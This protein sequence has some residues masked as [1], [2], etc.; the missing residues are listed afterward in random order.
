M[1]P[2]SI[3]KLSAEGS[4]VFVGQ[5]LVVVSSLVLVRLLTEHL[6]EQEY[7]NFTLGLTLAG[8]V[9]QTITGGV[10]AGM[11]R[12]YSVASESDALPEYHQ[13][14][15]KLNLKAS[16][17]I[18]SLIIPAAILFGIDGIQQHAL[19]IIFVISYAAL[20]S[21]FTISNSYYVASRKRRFSAINLVIDAWLRVSL[22]VAAVWAFPKTAESVFLGYLVASAIVCLLHVILNNSIKR[23]YRDSGENYFRIYREIQNYSMPFAIWGVFAWLQQS[24]DKWSLSYFHSVEST[25]SYAVLY[26]LGYSPMLMFCG[27]ITSFLAPIIFQKAGSGSDQER[28]KSTQDLIYKLTILGFGTVIAG[29]FFTVAFGDILIKIFVSD[30]FSVEKNYLHWL[31]LA[32]GLFSIGQLITLRLVSELNSKKLIPL[33]IGSSLLGVIYTVGLAKWYG[34]GGVVLSANLF[35]LTYLVWALMLIRKLNRNS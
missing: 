21:V 16:L 7:G 6:S 29:F 2:R 11:R 4:W 27:L 23:N 8:L 34:V 30:T 14:K 18:S 28:M 5:L 25:G 31:V 1:N 33:K 15:D 10:A 13:A 17:M 12:F 3:K 19:L 9:N 20:N 35:G 32:G 22:G 26:Q 24:V